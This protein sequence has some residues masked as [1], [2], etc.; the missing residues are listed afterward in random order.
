MVDLVKLRRR[1][2]RYRE[3][4]AQGRDGGGGKRAR[5]AR[6]ARRLRARSGRVAEFEYALM[7]AR[8]GGARSRPFSIRLPLPVSLR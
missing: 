6:S 3:R 7:F 5:G 2:G 8:D 4:E 1:H